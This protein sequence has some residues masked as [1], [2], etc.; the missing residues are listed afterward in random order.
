[1]K[2]YSLVLLDNSDNSFFSKNKVTEINKNTIRMQ[3]IFK[4]SDKKLY[5]LS[6]KLN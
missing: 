1:M 3:I 2:K 4:N 5:K 6:S